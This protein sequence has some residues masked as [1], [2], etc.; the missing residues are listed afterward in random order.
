MGM[1]VR[2]CGE[3]FLA[4]RFEILD[5]IQESNRSLRALRQAQCKLREAIPR[6]F[7]WGL[8]PFGFPFAALRAAAQ[9]RLSGFAL[10]AMTLLIKRLRPNAIM[11]ALGDDWLRRSRLDPN[12]EPRGADLVKPAQNSSAKSTEYAALPLAA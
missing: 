1:R 12:C 9:G 3:M 8:P 5:N 6:I 11:F 2:D 10:L 7:S 4:K